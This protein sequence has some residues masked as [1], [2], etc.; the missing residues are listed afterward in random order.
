MNTTITELQNNIREEEKYYFQKKA[1]IIY[2]EQNH[3]FYILNDWKNYLCNNN[4]YPSGIYQKERH[5]I[6]FLNYLEN[7]E[8]IPINK[9]TKKDILN[10]IDTFESY[11]RKQTIK[12]KFKELRIILRFLYKFN[13]INDNLSIFVPNIKISNNSNIPSYWN[14]EEI[15]K[16]F[17]QIDTFEKNKKRLYLVLILA[18]RYGLRCS[19]IKKLK[20]S[21]LNW[22]T[23]RINIIQSKTKKE[24]SLPMSLEFISAL[25][26]YLKNERP[27]S[28]SDTIILSQKSKSPLSESYNFHYAI[29]ILLRKANITYSKNKKIGIHSM[30]HT[31]ASSLL[32]ENIPLPIISTIL[33]HSNTSSTT[34]YL[35]INKEQLV[36][37][38]L[39]LEGVQLDD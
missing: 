9:L 14:E 35:K 3:Y 26:D 12:S 6:H 22:D 27:E 30:R 32:N 21:S 18:F 11:Y 4:Y 33:G 24:I 23:K 16:I 28:N 20:F 19:D 2:N 5:M 7:N 37:C 29:K 17:A 25:S 15:K 34:I 10:Y 1:K 38:C 13:Y 8:I 39:L 31:L 36:K